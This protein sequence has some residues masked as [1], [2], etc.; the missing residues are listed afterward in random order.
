MRSDFRF[1]FRFSSVMVYPGHAMVGELG[2]DD[3][4]ANLG[5][6]CLCSYA[7]LLPSDNLKCYL[8]FLY[9]TGACPSCN[10]VPVRIPQSSAIFVIP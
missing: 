6:C 5:F 4:L 3:D 8:L 9:L 1:E 2:S 10:P 7:C